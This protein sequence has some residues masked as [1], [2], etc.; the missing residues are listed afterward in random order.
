MV[1]QFL[2]HK[3]QYLKTEPEI[4]QMGVPRF[5]K[6]LLKSTVELSSDLSN[7]RKRIDEVAETYTRK[8]WKY[9]EE[10]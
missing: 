10:D 9:G 7:P 6:L 2:V 1:Q 4:L 3:D 5:R 8:K